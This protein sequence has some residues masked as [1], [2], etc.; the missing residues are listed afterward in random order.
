MTMAISEDTGNNNNPSK[1]DIERPGHLGNLMSNGGPP[2]GSRGGGPN[3]DM[4]EHQSCGGYSG[5]TTS[6]GP[7]SAG[8]KWTPQIHGG[9]WEEAQNSVMEPTYAPLV[10]V[11]ISIKVRS[12]RGKSYI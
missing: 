1:K 9:S 4:M 6:S 5:R 7:P 8:N 11:I 3:I 12:V 10:K 2:P